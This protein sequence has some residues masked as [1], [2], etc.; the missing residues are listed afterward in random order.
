MFSNPFILLTIL[1]SCYPLT[2]Q[3]KPHATGRMVLP[4]LK[5][6]ATMF[7]AMIPATAHAASRRRAA[8][9]TVSALVAILSSYTVELAQIGRGAHLLVQTNTV[10]WVCSQ[11][12]RKT[13]QTHDANSELL[14]LQ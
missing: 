14:T 8:L 7:L 1:S 10:L 6:R 9:P 11:P 12:A 5:R 3:F 13:S 4:L 2:S